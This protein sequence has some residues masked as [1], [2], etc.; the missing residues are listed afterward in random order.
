M[1]VEAFLYREEVWGRSV[2]YVDC[3]SIPS[4]TPRRRIFL[5]VD[6]TD[7]FWPAQRQMIQNVLDTLAGIL[8]S[9]DVCILWVM[10]EDRPSAERPCDRSRKWHRVLF[11]SLQPFDRGSWLTHT[12]AG[13]SEMASGSD[14]GWLDYLLIVSDGAIHDAFAASRPACIPSERVVMITPNENSAAKRELGVWRSLRRTWAPGILDLLRHQAQDLWLEPISG[15]HEE[16]REDR[17]LAVYRY[18]PP[19]IR[20]IGN[21]LKVVLG[22]HGIQLCYLNG[23]EPVPRLHAG[24]QV[25]GFRWIVKQNGH[26]GAAAAMA[27]VAELLLAPWNLDVL[28]KLQTE[29]TGE[30]EHCGASRQVHR[31]APNDLAC[32]VCR[33]CELVLD[34]QGPLKV[35]PSDASS[36][37][38]FPLPLKAGRLP[39]YRSPA[40]V[41]KPCYEVFRENEKDYL[42]LDF[43]PGSFGATLLDD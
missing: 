34:G 35:K 5:V 28:N 17:A 37:L 20:L 31:R 12:L 7:S 43:T 30:V 19:P 26:P 39:E 16:D 32:P 14:S 6:T 18:D 13:I 22:G 42:V 11:E 25:Y 10:G 40:G 8:Q 29:G 23:D 24:S 33:G 3:P 36:V 38:L 15:S 2:W 27:R 1:E 21:R 4:C 41:Q 9:D